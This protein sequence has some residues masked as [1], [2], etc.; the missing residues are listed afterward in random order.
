MMSSN[1]HHFGDATCSKESFLFRSCHAWSKSS[2][3]SICLINSQWATSIEDGDK[4]DHIFSLFLVS[5]VFGWKLYITQG[6][7]W[8]E[9]C[10]YAAALYLPLDV[11]RTGC[12][13]RR[14]LSL[15][16]RLGDIWSL[17]WFIISEEEGFSLELDSR[18]FNVSLS[19]SSFIFWNNT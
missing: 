2:A 6:K 5:K 10:I 16:S 1:S 4:Q 13:P 11:E 9:C 19:L 17:A 14:S 8:L 3:N 15:V 12:N 7:G 18:G